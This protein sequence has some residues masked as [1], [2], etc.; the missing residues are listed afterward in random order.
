MHGQKKKMQ[1]E[2]TKRN[3]K[4]VRNVL[5]TIPSRPCSDIG[6]HNLITRIKEGKHK[7]Q[8]TKKEN[9]KK[10]TRMHKKKQ[11]KERNQF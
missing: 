10:R 7:Q 4:T 6:L 3:K 11:D 5:L 2:N 8:K 1:Q 9:Q